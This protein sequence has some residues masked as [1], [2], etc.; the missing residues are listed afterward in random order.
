MQSNYLPWRGYF[1]LMRLADVFIYLDCVQYTRSDWRNRNVIK[2][3]SGPRWMT[4]PVRGHL[5]E[6]IDEVQVARPSWAEGHILMIT[7]NYR[8]A[9]HFEEVSPWLFEKMR[10]AAPLRSLV[11]VNH[12]LASAI[13]EK[14]M[15]GT[16]LRVSTDVLPRSELLGCSASERVARLVAAVGGTRYLSGPAAKTYLEEAPFQERNID[17]AWMSYDGYSQYPQ[18]WEGYE[19]NVSV[20]DLLLNC[21]FDRSVGL[22]GARR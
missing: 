22:I 18:C 6:A 8:H 14:L 13:R 4:V 10:Q 3:S 5:G 16:P 12:Y 17:I 7:P 9:A 20:I 11:E 19:P 15:I 21:G 1:D 2:T